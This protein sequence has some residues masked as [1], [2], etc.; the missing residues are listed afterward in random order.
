MSSHSHNCC[1]QITM[2]IYIN[3]RTYIHACLYTQSQITAILDIKKIV[4][5]CVGKKVVFLNKKK[6]HK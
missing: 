6:I 1:V 2:D 3:T 5:K 4:N